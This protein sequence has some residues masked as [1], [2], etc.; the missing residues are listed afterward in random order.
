M[1]IYLAGS[2]SSENRS[3]MMKAKKYIE[4]FN[5]EVYAPFMLKIPNAWDYSQEEWAEL[6]FKRD[7]N[8]L[9]SADCVIAITPGRMSSAG[10][11]FEIGYAYG[12]G[13]P[14]YVL[15]NTNESTSLM[16]YCGCNYFA[17][18]EKNFWIEFKWLLG[19]IA[20]GDINSYEKKCFTVLT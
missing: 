7:I 5:F 12:I 2:C 11:N 13:K 15:Q 19:H 10:V 1:K 3:L 9:K 8:E 4:E 17:S 18:N 16:I 6:V 14:V 20:I